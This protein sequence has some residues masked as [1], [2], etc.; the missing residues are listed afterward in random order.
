MNSL[1]RNWDRQYSCEVSMMSLGTSRIAVKSL[2]KV[3]DQQYSCETSLETSRIAR[4]SLGRVWGP[5][6]KQGNL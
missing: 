5:T 4:K 3:K 1:G 2:G 6:G